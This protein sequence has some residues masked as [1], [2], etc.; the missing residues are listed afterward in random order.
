M[1]TE[2]ARAARVLVRFADPARDAARILDVYRPYILETAVTF[3]EEVPSLPAF[4]RRV[5]DIAGEFPYL[6]VEVD[7]VLAGYA[8]AHRQAERAAYRYNAELSVY[9]APAFTHRGLGKPLYALL[10][11]LLQAQGYLNFY[12]VITAS[13]ASSIAMHEAMGFVRCGLHVRTGYKFGCWHDVAWLVRSLPA[14]APGEICPVNALDGDQ[15]ATLLAGAA[16][17]MDGRL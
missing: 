6:L 7:G 5:A 12:G 2:Q 3:E 13:N 17:E 9:L 4:T 16:Q 10:M 11:V 14:D 15:V 8:Y 1:R